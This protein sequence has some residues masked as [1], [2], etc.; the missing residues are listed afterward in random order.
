MKD[1]TLL[2]LKTTTEEADT[3][4]KELKVAG[5]SFQNM[6]RARIFVDNADLDVIRDWFQN[7]GVDSMYAQTTCAV[8][9]TDETFRVHPDW[10]HLSEPEALLYQY[11]ASKY[12]FSNMDIDLKKFQNFL[13]GLIYREEQNFCKDN[14][15]H[16]NY[17]W[18][19]YESPFLNYGRERLVPTLKVR[20]LNEKGYKMV[21]PGEV[22]H[23][24]D[25]RVSFGVYARK[26]SQRK[27]SLPEKIESAKLKASAPKP[28]ITTEKE[29]ER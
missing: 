25:V 2:F 18:E 20:I 1:R 13:F 9:D 6:Y 15:I 5:Y 21:D 19:L 23:E 24:K 11:I 12:D 29:T 7:R 28:S 4:L 8:K 3:L 14:G 10:F 27:V 17:T 16:G 26:S 22:D